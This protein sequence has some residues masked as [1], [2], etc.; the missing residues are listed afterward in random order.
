MKF[1]QGTTFDSKRQALEYLLEQG[2]VMVHLDARHPDVQVPP[3]LRTHSHLKLNLSYRFDVD[4]FE[5]TDI[6]AQASLSFRGT[7][8]FCLMPYSAIFALNSHVI[9]QFFIWPETVP[10][11]LAKNFSQLPFETMPNPTIPAA[12]APSP[13]RI[14][15]GD[16]E[17]TP[18]E[19]A[20]EEEATE[21]KPAPR[22]PLL[23]VATPEE[24]PPE[25]STPEEPTPEDPGP[26]DKPTR[27]YGHLKVIK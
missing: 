12:P 16:A 14:I 8:S 24:A 15:N 19:E 13:F 5:V 27:R 10:A 25:A 18:E 7:R 23:A 6:G 3:Y 17:E 22:S 20:T 11:E 21:E 4:D 1:Y 26:E 2:M 9:P